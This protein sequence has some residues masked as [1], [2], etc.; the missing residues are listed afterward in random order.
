MIEFLVSTLLIVGGTF[1]LIGT[2]GLA[3]FPDFYTRLHGPSK[4]S[5]LGVGSIL[6]ASLFQFNAMG[7]F[8]LKELLIT[9][10]IFITTP[11][12][13]HVLCKAALQTRLR[14]VAP[15]PTEAQKEPVN[16]P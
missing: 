4:G 8:G 10:L 12:S 13:A 9:F 7:Q 15:L 5:T 1:T 14:S 11:V 6:L 2:I 16:A 3:R